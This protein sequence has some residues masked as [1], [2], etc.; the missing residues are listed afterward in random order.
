[1]LSALK[2]FV[3]IKPRSYTLSVPYAEE[4]EGLLLLGD[5]GTGK[6]QAIHQLLDRITERDSNEAVIIYDPAGEFIEGHFNP[7]TDIVVNPLDARCPYWAPH[8]EITEGNEKLSAPERQFIAESFFP[9]PDDASPTARFF[10][11]AARAILTL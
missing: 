3:G 7:A 10:I 11:M 1:M 8:L 6:S 2:E 4:N 9:C 5:P